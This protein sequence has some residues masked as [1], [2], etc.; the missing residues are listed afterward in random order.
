V[1]KGIWITGVLVAVL[2]ILSSIAVAAGT[3]SVESTIGGTSLQA[4]SN[5]GRFTI[6]PGGKAYGFSGS[7]VVMGF[8]GNTI[9]NFMIKKVDEPSA[10]V[11]F[12]RNVDGKTDSPVP[13]ASLTLG[14]G[15]YVL[16][17]GGKAGGRAVISFTGENVS[18]GQ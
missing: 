13:L 2:V 1:K 3:Y 9:Y 6:A 18:V 12:E 4:E 10:K 8:D 15:K 11:V 7:S 14:P 17:I 16:V 5:L